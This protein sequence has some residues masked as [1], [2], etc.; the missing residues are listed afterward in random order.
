MGSDEENPFKEVL[1]RVLAGTVA[2][3]I[4]GTVIFLLYVL[5]N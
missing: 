3:L 5:S 1:L 2:Y 4:A